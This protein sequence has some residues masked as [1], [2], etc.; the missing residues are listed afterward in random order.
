MLGC[1][2][3][4][5][6][7]IILPSDLCTHSGRSVGVVARVDMIDPDRYPVAEIAVVESAP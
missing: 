6:Q 1:V 5:V 4:G 2:V 7:G 3:S